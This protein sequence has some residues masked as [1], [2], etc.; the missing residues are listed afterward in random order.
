MFID[1]ENQ[2]VSSARNA[3]IKEA[4]G[5]YTMFIDSDDYID[6]DMVE[7][8]Y[9][10]IIKENSDLS[11]CN[12]YGN[13]NFSKISKIINKEEALDY[14]LDKDKF[15]GYPVNKLYKTDYV[16]EI[17]FNKDI[18]ICEDLLF[19]CQYLARINKISIIDEYLYHYTRY[20]ILY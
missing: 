20:P 11:I 5:E 14:I 1:Q 12:V 2:G 19:N 16:K 17:L 3:G 9:Q 4:S 15:R 7:K 10:S 13:K 18:R 8:L 6:S